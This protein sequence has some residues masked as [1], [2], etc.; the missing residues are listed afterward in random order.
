MS[1]GL[2]YSNVVGRACCIS[3]RPL[4]TSKK[5]HDWSSPKVISALNREPFGE[6][7]ATRVAKRLETQ[8]LNYSH[9]FYCGHGLFLHDNVF[10]L[11]ELQ[12]GYPDER[13]GSKK[14]MEW[15]TQKTFV[16]WLAKQSDYSLSGADPDHEMFEETEFMRNNQRITRL[17]CIDFLR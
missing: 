2:R 3:I 7:L 17:R 13:A 10:E 11:W 12:E 8:N 16:A 9:Q 4:T 15:R 14:I 1:H 5:E 6:D